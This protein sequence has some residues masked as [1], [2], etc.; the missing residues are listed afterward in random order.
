MGWISNLESQ[1]RDGRREANIQH[2]DQRPHVGDGSERDQS[3]RTSGYT[4]S[5]QNEK[6]R[7]VEPSFLKLEIVPMF[8]INTSRVPSRYC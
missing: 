6:E 8:L 4:I 5:M 3:I 7:V 1:W 2:R